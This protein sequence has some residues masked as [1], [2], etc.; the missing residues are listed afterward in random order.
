MPAAAGAHLRGMAELQRAFAHSSREAR[1]VVRREFRGIAEPIAREAEQLSLSRIRHMPG[2][3]RWAQ[4]RI[5]VTRRAVYV[6]PKKRGVR[7]RTDPR[8]RQNLAGLLMTRAMEPALQHH[9]SSITHDVERALDRI[10][11]H[12]NHGRRA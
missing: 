3:P 10:A 2:S 7:G 5:G 6:A 4:M 8:R 1:T 12:F 9:E 11:D